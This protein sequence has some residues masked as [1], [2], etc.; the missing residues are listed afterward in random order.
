MFLWGFLFLLPVFVSAQV[1]DAWR[2]LCSSC[3]QHSRCCCKTSR[4]QT[5]LWWASLPCS[6]IEEEENTHMHKANH[7]SVVVRQGGAG[8]DNH[9][10]RCGNSTSNRWA[11]DQT[12][13]SG[14]LRWPQ[15]LLC[16]GQD[17]GIPS[18]HCCSHGPR[19]SVMHLHLIRPQIRKSWD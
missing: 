10:K 2:H 12:H 17:C 5:L 6:H 9:E 8:H 4:G 14:G 7:F 16:H 11:G 18:S 3:R 19:R 1:W 13:Q 15:R